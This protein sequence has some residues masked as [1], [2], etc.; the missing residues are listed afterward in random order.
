MRRILQIGR[1]ASGSV[2]AE[3]GVERGE[4]VED[5]HELE[6]EIVADVGSFGVVAYRRIPGELGAY[7]QQD[8]SSF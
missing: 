1:V 6:L 2:D 8:V 5:V 7:L 4:V 3:L